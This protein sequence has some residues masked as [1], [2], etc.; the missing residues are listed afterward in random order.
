MHADGTYVYYTIVLSSTEVRVRLQRSLVEMALQLAHNGAATLP[1]PS[2]CARPPSSPYCWHCSS[3]AAHWHA[4]ARQQSQF[5]RHMAIPH[6][7]PLS[8]I[9]GR[10]C[11]ADLVALAHRTTRRCCW[12]RHPLWCLRTSRRSTGRATGWLS[13]PLQRARSLVAALRTLWCAP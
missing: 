7:P 2:L 6:P 3:P 9:A 5:Q 12:Q 8:V 4:L 13:M 1:Q 11:L 10:I